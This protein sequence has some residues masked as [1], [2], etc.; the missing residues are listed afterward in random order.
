RTDSG[1]RSC[2]G[3]RG[4]PAWCRGW[5]ACNKEGRSRSAGR[6]RS[7]RSIQRRRLRC[8]HLS[9]EVL[10]AQ[11]GGHH[12]SPDHVPGQPP[13]GHEVALRGLVALAAG[14]ESHRHGDGEINNDNDNIDGA[15]GHAAGELMHGKG[16]LT[17]DSLRDF[18]CRLGGG[19]AFR[20]AVFYIGLHC[21]IALHPPSTART[22]PVIYAASSE[23]RKTAAPP[24]SC[25][26]PTRPRKVLAT[27][28]L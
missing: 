18:R 2:S 7:R 1:K 23:A 9:N 17:R 11:I 22:V 15:K 16:S 13:V 24:I 5:I 19:S 20:P 28:R 27:C 4:T 25:G 14:V 21:Y 6:T 12:G 3:V 26:W 8:S 10:R